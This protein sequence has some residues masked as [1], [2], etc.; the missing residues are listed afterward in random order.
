M[1]TGLR[2]G[3]GVL[4]IV[5]LFLRPFYWNGSASGFQI[6]AYEHNVEA[7]AIFLASLALGVIAMISTFFTKRIIEWLEMT[8]TVVPVCGIAF[9][10]WRFSVVEHN[11]VTLTWAGLCLVAGLSFIAIG[12]NGRYRNS[13][14]HD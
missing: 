12:A 7:I 13:G 4:F 1:Y 3:G 10:L 5:A 11:G 9:F 8:L 6:A 14:H 2:I